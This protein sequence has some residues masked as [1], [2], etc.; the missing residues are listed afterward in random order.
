MFPKNLLGKPWNLNPGQT[1]SQIVPSSSKL[2]LGKDLR[3]VAKR[4][5]SFFVSIRKSQKRHFCISLANNRLMDVTQLALT[6]VGWPNGEK[7]AVT[8]VEIWSWTKL[9]A[10]HRKSTQVYASPGQTESQVDPS[11]QLASPYG[12]G[13]TQK[14]GLPLYPTMVEISRC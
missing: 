4:L 6:W 5:A 12:Q 14:S 1:E 2:N 11:F 7:L 10:S 9:T 3:W 8:C 13:F